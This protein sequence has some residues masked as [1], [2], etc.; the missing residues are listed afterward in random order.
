M[1]F[2]RFLEHTQLIQSIPAPTF[3]EGERSAWMY[4]QFKQMGLSVLDQDPLGNVFACISG[5]EKAPLIISAHLDTVFP[6]AQDLQVIRTQ[7]KL[8]GPG[9]GDNALGLATLIELSEDLQKSDLAG[10]IWLVANVG[11][12]G[13]GNLM[14]MRKVVN[15]FEDR[16]CA[17]LI[18]EGMAY[19]HIYIRGLPVRRYRI[20][21]LGS[22]GHSWIHKQ[23]PSAIDALVKVAH[24]IIDI[25]L[26]ESPRTTLNIG[27][28][29]GGTSINS[30]ASQAS[31]ELDLRSESE[32][33]LEDLIQSI[34]R[35]VH[36]RPIPGIDI[37]MESI[38]SRPGG[39]I[40][41]EHQLVQAARRALLDSGLE[42]CYLDS[43]STDANIPLSQGLPAICV[44]LT[45]GGNAHTP[46]EFI[47]IQPIHAGY[48]S[49]LAM[50]Y[51]ILDNE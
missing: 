50:I 41:P 31:F 8:I 5:G 14:G 40:N 17:Y 39:G 45:R 48:Q 47:E 6:I 26:P 42:Q 1:N 35:T 32:S 49:V 4:S 19:G 7:N 44:G 34:L 13:L 16:A 11:E 27:T 46:Q 23:R 28:I 21:T 3:A 9:I 36:D 43:G 37:E 33:I 20:L 29:E 51:S 12:E 22:G 38:G 10:D 15:R 24:R 2:E 25:P 30:V 18:L